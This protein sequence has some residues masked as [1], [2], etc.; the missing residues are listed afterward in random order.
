MVAPNYAAQRSELAKRSGLGQLRKS[1]AAPAKKAAAAAGAPRK[2]GR[3]AKAG[4]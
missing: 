4:A 3:P 1:A 2:R